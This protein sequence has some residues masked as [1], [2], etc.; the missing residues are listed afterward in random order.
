MTKEASTL[1]YIV[2]EKAKMTYDL[3]HHNHNLRSLQNQGGTTTYGGRYQRSSKNAAT[4]NNFD[5]I[6]LCITLVVLVSI[7]LYTIWLARRSKQKLEQQLRLENELRLQQQKRQ[8]QLILKRHQLILHTFNNN[9][10]SHNNIS[11]VSFIYTCDCMYV[12]MYVCVCSIY[13]FIF[14][15]FCF[16]Y[17]KTSIFFFRLCK[18][19]I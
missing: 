4:G 19:V 6:H 2:F 14:V 16:P 1:L 17:K 5:V 18:R 8:Q 15:L 7:V 12:C 10:T 11:M 9:E 3:H 13:F